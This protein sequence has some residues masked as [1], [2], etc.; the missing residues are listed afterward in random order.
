MV[1]I[2][3]IIMGFLMLGEGYDYDLIGLGLK[4]S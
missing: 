2:I 4:V 3:I 1:I